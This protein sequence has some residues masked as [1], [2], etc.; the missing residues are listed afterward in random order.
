[1]LQPELGT[2]EPPM[3]ADASAAAAALANFAWFWDQETDPSERNK[4]LGLIFQEVT[5][6]RIGA[7]FHLQLEL[8]VA[9]ISGG[10]FR[11]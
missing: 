8:V 1:V 5:V 9:A 7:G 10:G 6:E 2:L 11:Y 4:I 3:L